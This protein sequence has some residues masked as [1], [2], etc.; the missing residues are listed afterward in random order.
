MTFKKKKKQERKDD[1]Q[2]GNWSFKNVNTFFIVVSLFYM[3]I[4]GKKIYS[5]EFFFI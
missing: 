4:T 5:T 2:V 3:K 1:H